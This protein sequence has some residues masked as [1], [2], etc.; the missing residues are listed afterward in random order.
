MEKEELLYR[1]FSNTLSQ[2][3]RNIFNELLETDPAFKANFEFHNQLK[4]ATKEHRHREISKK[5]QRFE[6]D[7]IQKKQEENKGTISY[8]KIA[9]SILFLV[10]AS[11]F[12]YLTFSGTDYEELY[13]QN[14]SPYPNTVYVIT[15]S[16]TINTVERE[17]FV[18]YESG[19]YKLAL[20]KMST[21]IE[22]PYMLFYKAQSFLSLDMIKEAETLVCRRVTLVPGTH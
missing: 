10:A 13:A 1:Y 11:C 7:I 9:A 21:P 18:A 22:Q 8:W 4:Q 16:D 19:D 2:E 14:I 20:A 6:S 3:E 12:A 15:R 17:A 5:L